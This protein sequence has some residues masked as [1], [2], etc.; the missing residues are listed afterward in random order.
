MKYLVEVVLHDCSY[1]FY[2]GSIF[3]ADLITFQLLTSG[4]KVL[5]RF[6]IDAVVSIR[7]FN[8]ELMKFRQYDPGAFDH[9]FHYITVE[10][11]W[12]DVV[13]ESEGMICI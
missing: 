10:E 6:D 11:A 2:G 1:A 12:N 8:F 5:K 3:D 13:F 4:Y 7:I 9:G